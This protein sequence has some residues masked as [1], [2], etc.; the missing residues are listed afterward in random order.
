MIRFFFIALFA[1]ASTAHPAVSNSDGLFRRDVTIPSLD[2]FYAAPS[3]LSAYAP[4]AI[5]R[6]RKP[7]SALSFYNLPANLAGAWQLLYR[8]N[9]VN[10]EPLATVT[11]VMVPHNANYERL[12]SYQV[13]IDAPYSGCFP[14]YT[15]QKGGSYVDNISAQYGELWYITALQ[16]GWVV[17]S[18]DHEG[19]NAAFG[20][21]ILGGHA[22]LDGLRA[23]IQ[24]TS[25]TG[26]LPTAQMAMWGY[27]GGSQATEFALELHD[28]Y[29]PE[30]NITAAALG[31][32][33]VNFRNVISNVDK[34][35]GAGLI[36][37][38]SLG[39]ARAYPGLKTLVDNS[40]YS[41]N[42]SQFLRAEDQCV[43]STVVDF[44]FDDP[45][46]YLKN[47]SAVL[48]E[49]AAAQAL[50]DTVMGQIGTPKVPTYV[51]HAI[52]DELLPFADVVD[53]YNKYC[54]AGANIHFTKEAFGEHII[55]ALT[56]AASALGF[57][58]D[59]FDGK[60]LASGCSQKTVL[61]SALDPSSIS[62]LGQF[63]YNDVVSL[64]GK[65]IGPSA[66]VQKK[67]SKL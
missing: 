67:A 20:A 37:G 17:S 15:L 47:G 54:A 27:S 38:A 51:Y 40:L 57:L 35:I 59:R 58:M 19:P 3:N 5:I 13:E 41:S 25:I 36:P 23:V 39:L 65:S 33:P 50:Q 7:P 22:T 1:M 49:P 64:L 52:N 26:V 48:N 9:G 66:W 24:S 63:V 44:A 55:V 60:A 18:P 32:L 21:G 61:S 29:A 2:P 4:G 6:S 10:G 16:K 46:T 34:A 56:G 45:F 30:L 62:I 42:K 43:V 53:L 14:S 8:T 31:G 28:S 12:L 11:T